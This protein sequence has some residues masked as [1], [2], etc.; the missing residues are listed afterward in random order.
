MSS[1]PDETAPAA[2]EPRFRRPTKEDALTLAREQFLAGERVEMQTLAAQLDVNRTTLYRWV[3]ERD[4]LL[5]Q[6][7]AALVD[8]W[9][10]LLMPTA[11]G[12]GFERF[13]DV[14]RRMLEFGA[15]FE[16]LTLF[17]QREPA[18]ALR[19]IGERGGAVALRS[20]EAV[21]RVLAESEPDV[22]VPAEVVGAISLVSRTLVW[23]N[24]A[25]GSD[26]DVEGPVELARTL[27]ESCRIRAG[28]G[29][30]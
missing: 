15:S 2:V 5:G 11:E 26:P 28:V 13:L 19:I 21:A 6:L 1:R 4:Q 27:L 10:E 14:L 17:T 24:I 22:P 29:A 16:P 8:E 12:E 3:G 23:A 9:L 7:F 18:L 30:G 25:S 20:E